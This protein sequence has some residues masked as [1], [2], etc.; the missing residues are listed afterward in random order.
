MS[1][2]TQIQQILKN[3]AEYG[4]EWEVKITAE[5]YMQEDSE[6]EE[7]DAYIHAYNDW[8]K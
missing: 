6:M 7:I 1:K 8:I 3:A 5:N 2:E 4:L